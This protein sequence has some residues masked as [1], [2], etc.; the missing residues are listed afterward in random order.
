VV[1]GA[2]GVGINSNTFG[3]ISSQANGA[4]TIQFGLKL[5]F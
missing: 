1:F 2:P 4:R 5:L 3:I